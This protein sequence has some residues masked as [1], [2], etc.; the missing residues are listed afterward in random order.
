[1]NSKIKFILLVVF[2]KITCVL[3][4]QEVIETI[5][6]VD[7]VLVNVEGDSMIKPFYIGAFEVTQNQWEKVMGTSVLQQ[8]DLI[9]SDYPM[10]GVGENYPMYYVSW[11]DAKA[12]CKR[13]SV[14]TGRT[15]RLPTEIEW[16]YAAR[17]GKH[18]EI[19]MY[20]GGTCIDSVAWYSFNSNNSAHQCGTKQPNVL[21]I[22]DL[23][24][25]VW[26]WCED[27]S[28]TC[29]SDSNEDVSSSRYY[30][31]RGGSWFCD[32][33]CCEI[34]NR[35]SAASDY[36]IYHIGFRVVLDP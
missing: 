17:G 16:E 1:M 6:G 15:Y 5:L 29:S 11:D 2:M 4:A 27:N 35:G 36:S 3:S 12:F 33:S 28:L 14:R 34:T 13:L 31:L 21:G 20:S 19:A 9:N 10:R 32:S 18:Y 30:I 23:S 22:Y 8:K 26:E 25:N 7:M 24:G